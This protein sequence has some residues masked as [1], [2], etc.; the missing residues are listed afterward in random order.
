MNLKI[1]LKYFRQKLFKGH[2]ERFLS[3]KFFSI[4]TNQHKK[5]NI[6]ILD[7][8]SGFKPEIAF[9]LSKKFKNKRYN[10]QINC[11]D[12]YTKKDLNKL[13]QQTNIKF[14][15]LKYL[16]TKNKY[17]FII[18]SD[19]LHHIGVMN[20]KKISSILKDLKKY[21]KYILIKDH[22]EYGLFSRL[23][24]ILMDFIGNYYNNVNTAFRFFKQ[25]NFHNVLS[26]AELRIVKKFLNIRYYNKYFIFFNNPKLHFIYLLK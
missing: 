13:N 11:Y 25:K 5:K 22:F 9:Y 19:V 21:G 17:D 8:G 15:N 20:E 4:I 26:N 23:L 14:F 12:F 6:R 3:K 2:R 18:I 16:D 7:F 10:V 24:L 1:F